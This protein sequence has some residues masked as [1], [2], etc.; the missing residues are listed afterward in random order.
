M[1]SN[2]SSLVSFRYQLSTINFFPSDLGFF[3]D[4]FGG[5]L[6]RAFLEHAPLRAV[7][8]AYE[9]LIKFLGG[10]SRRLDRPIR[11]VLGPPPAHQLSRP[12]GHQQ[13][14]PELAVHPFGHLLDHVVSL[15][16]ETLSVCAPSA[17]PGEQA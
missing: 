9:V 14:Q 12:P 3:R 1:V 2:R 10:E 11:L 7:V 8:P 17:R 16:S 5:G 15:S 13:S 4:L 6:R